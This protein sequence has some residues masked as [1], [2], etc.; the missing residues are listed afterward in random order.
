MPTQINLL[1]QK[2]PF[3]ISGSILLIVNRLV[4]VVI[5]ALAGYFGWSFL[6]VKD[7]TKKIESVKFDIA[8]KKDAFNKISRSD[9]LITRQSQVKEYGN[10]IKGHLYWSQLLPEIAKVTLKQATFLSLQTDSKYALSLSVQLPN[11]VELDKFLQVFNSPTLNKYFRDVK[12]SGIS[13]VQ[14]DDQNLIKADITFDFN[15]KIIQYK[16]K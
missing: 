13:K 8:G 16:E 5:L 6:K 3:A 9:E 12:I 15:P 7:Y 4:I 11:M 1:K 10:L 14:E 2:S